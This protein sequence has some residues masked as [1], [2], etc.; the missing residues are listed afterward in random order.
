MKRYAILFMLVLGFLPGCAVLNVEGAWEK[1]KPIVL[2]QGAIAADGYIDQMVAD[3]KIT[4]EQ[5]EA[6]K[7]AVAD[8]AVSL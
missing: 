7:K 4:P 6:L 2:E 8:L 3:G 1:V 5:A